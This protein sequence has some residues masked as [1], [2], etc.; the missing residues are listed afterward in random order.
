MTM[1]GLKGI[2]FH[3][4]SVVRVIRVGIGSIALYQALS[5]RDGMIGVFAVL[6]LVQGIMNWSC[7]GAGS[8]DTVESK[9]KATDVTKD[10][11]YEEVKPM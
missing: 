6:L 7:C 11:E 4:W 3:N 8:C 2:I 10:V 9:F 5:L 1:A